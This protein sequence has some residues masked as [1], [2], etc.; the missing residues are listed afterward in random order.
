MNNKQKNDTYKASFILP[1]EARENIEKIQEHYKKE[2]GLKVNK[3]SIVNRAI[4][5]FSKKIA[6]L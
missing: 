1:S 2:E 6:S 4:L 3:S 5:E